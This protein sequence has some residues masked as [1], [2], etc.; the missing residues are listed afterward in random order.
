MID[1]LR[2]TYPL[3]LLCRV[4]Q[5]ARSSHY[6]RRQRR[7]EG[8]LPVRLRETQGQWPTYGY[9]RITAQLQCEG[10]AISQ[11]RVRRLRKLLHLQ[12]KIKAKQRR[13]TNSQHPFPRY[14]N[15]V[16]DLTVTHPDHV[17]VCDIT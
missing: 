8:A 11:N 13:T 10:V 17:W 3:E 1:Q 4:L 2:K 15:L 7:D 9:R 5:Y 16:Q 14:P 12:A 6:Y